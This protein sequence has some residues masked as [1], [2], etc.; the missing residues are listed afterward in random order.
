M[1]EVRDGTRWID[2]EFEKRR[3]N[4]EERRDTRM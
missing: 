3:W 2:Q 4:A 1:G